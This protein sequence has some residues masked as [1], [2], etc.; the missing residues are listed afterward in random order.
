MGKNI[1]TVSKSEDI[2]NYNENY[3]KVVDKKYENIDKKDYTFEKP[4]VIHNLYG[5]NALSLNIFFN[6]AISCYHC[7]LEDNSMSL[8]QIHTNIKT[9]YLHKD[10]ILLLRPTIHAGAEPLVGRAGPWPA[11]SF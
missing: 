3:R 2:D 6:V 5:T 9:L 8:S 10:S 7:Q 11:P 4:L 1:Y